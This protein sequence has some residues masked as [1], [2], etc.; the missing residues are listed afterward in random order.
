M[1][2]GIRTGTLHVVRGAEPQELDPHVTIGQTEHWL[3]LSLLEGLVSED[4]VDLHPVPGVAERWDISPDGRVFTFHLRANARW[5]NGDR[6]TA[7]D[8]VGSFRRALE[9]A[10][11]YQYAYMLY[12][13][14]NAEAFN[15]GALTDFNQVGFEVLDD[16][17]LRVTLQSPT[18]YFLSLLCH[19]SWFPV[20]LPTVARH[21]DP[22]SRG[23]VWTRPGHHVGN[24]AFQ[25]SDWR[26]NYEIV[27]KKSPTYWNAA[28]VRLNAIHFRAMENMD[29]EERAFRA[30]QL[31]VN[32]TLP[33]A[34]IERYRR[35]HPEVLRIDP[36]L[37][38]YFYRVNVTRPA[39]QDKRVR[40]ALNIA[41]D[42]EMLVRNVTRG[43]QL[44]ADGNVPPGTAGFTS[45]TRIPRDLAL[46]RRLLAE[47]GHPEGRGLPP[48][49]ILYNTN[50]DHRRLAEAIQQMWKNRLGI[51]AR[52]VNEEWKVY[53]ATMH[54]QKYDVCR[55]GWVGDYPDPNTF[56]DCWV[57]EGGNNDTGWSNAEYDRLIRLAA[58]TAD[59]AE[60]L[61]VFHRAEAILMEETPILPLYYYTRVFLKHTAVKGWNPTVNDDHPYQHLYLEAGPGGSDPARAALSILE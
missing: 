28:K 49:E 48:I 43:G 34:K 60:R 14:T 37:A 51:D 41:I 25:L 18:P 6:V 33:G 7:R 53:L 40:Q 36:H 31:H 2:A 23:T 1:E 44:P 27:V 15:T 24:G 5:S 52:I 20:H 26:V 12:V 38:T 61:E 8:F 42:R 35:D 59:K 32:Y 3:I 17:T 9:P 46:A 4:P 58:R 22:F 47:A 54:A 57:T 56:L 11:A 39:L 50:E 30:G 10:M 16:S 29:A 13:V 19:T 55:G 45:R 21:G